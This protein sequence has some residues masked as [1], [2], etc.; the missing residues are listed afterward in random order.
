MNNIINKIKQV[1]P[2]SDEAI[3]ALQANMQ[4]KYYPKNT[5]IVQSGVTDRLV[6]F[7][8]E[9][10][11]HSVFHHNGLDTTTWFSQEGDITF[12]MDSL[13]YQ[14]PS[15]ESIETLSD[16]KIYVIPIDKLNALYEK[17]IDIANWGRILHQDV[18]K[19]LSLLFVERLQLSP[20]ERYERF[21]QCYPGLVNRVKLKYVA[22]FLG[23]SIYTLSR[24]RAKK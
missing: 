16:C 13:Y 19:E 9:G 7:I 17:Y 5:C 11:T 20:K 14:H 22:A 24:I 21:N 8:E 18:N 4:V 2:V 15:I 23:I 12:G 6:Y 3:R 1:Y 10:I